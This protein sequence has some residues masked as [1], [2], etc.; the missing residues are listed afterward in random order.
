MNKKI[1]FL[2][3][4]LTIFAG[5][6]QVIGEAKAN[7]ETPVEVKEIKDL[8]LSDSDETKSVIGLRWC[9]NPTL[10]PTH[11]VFNLT[12]EVVYA[13]GAILIFDKQAESSVRSSR[14]EVPTLH[15]YRGKKPAI[16]KQIKAFVTTEILD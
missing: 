10:Q 2:V 6:S 5:V 12:L 8:G 14:I 3:L 15:I 11:S 4:V 1:G 13:D 16:I 7:P 9:V